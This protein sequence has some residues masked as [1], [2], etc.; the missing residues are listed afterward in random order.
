MNFDFTDEQLELREVILRF[1]R[2]ELTSDVVE[3]DASGAFSRQTWKACADAGIQ[4]LAVPEVYG[5]SGAD[6]LTTIVALEALG[7]GCNDNGLIFSLNAQMWAVQHPLERFGTEDQKR[8]YLPR[9][10][11][12]SLVG[13]HAMSEPGSGSD[14]AALATVAD[15]DGDQFRLSGSK[16]FVSNG[17]VADLFVIFARLE[18]SHGFMGLCAFVVERDTPGLS[19]GRPLSKMG[20]RTSPMCELFLDECP[21]AAAQMLG[22]QGRGM[23][24]FASSMDRERSLI[25][26]S[27]VGS[28]A[29]VLDRCLD[30]AR[31]REQFGQRIG[32]FQAVSHR[33]VEMKLRLE[34][35]RLLLY[36]L[37]WSL[38]RGGRVALDAALVKLHLSESL[39]ANGLDALQTFGGYGYMTEYEI[40]R[41]VRDA[42]G[43]RIY[44]G[45]SDMQRNLAARE[46]G[47]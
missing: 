41:E 27:T 18:G 28:M 33:I 1:A 13:G 2:R 25:L 17:P 47:L 16:S 46:L 6:A 35:S 38:D 30:H 9:L 23:A 45:T 4:G 36:Q 14:A 11:D 34:T 7:Y 31:E 24:V 5:G 10:C 40:E 37:G 26:A 21:V 39:V 15:K 19:F 3:Q 29:R 43:S 20:L 8:K 44:S 12:G 22:A 32:K 42:I